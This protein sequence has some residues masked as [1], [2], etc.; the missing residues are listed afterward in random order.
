MRQ[1]FDHA[2][3]VDGLAR[4]ITNEASRGD[5]FV[6]AAPRVRADGKKAAVERV[7]ALWADCDDDAAVTALAEF[8]PE[9]AFVVQTGSGSN[10]QAWWPLA[11]WIAPEHAER[12]NR[13]L[14]HALGSDMRATDAARIL[15]PPGTLNHKHDPPRP[16]ECVANVPGFVTLAAICTLPDPPQETTRRAVRPA[17]GKRSEGRTDDLLAI[18][19][20]VYV[21]RLSGREVNLAGMVQCPFHK[22]GQELTPSLRAYD[23][24]S[25]GFYCFGCREGGSIY[26]FAAKLWGMGTRGD[27]FKALRKRLAEELA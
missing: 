3:A 25:Q 23:E 24:T 16:V 9:P 7:W 22:S 8:E 6:G 17:A 4:H 5:V 13:K 20:T 1:Y 18:P 21:P 26:D 14:A 27:D 10:V 12:L 11:Q 19:A 2:S 15:R